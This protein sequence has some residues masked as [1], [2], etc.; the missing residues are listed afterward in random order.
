MPK[1]RRVK[2]AGKSSIRK[3]RSTIFYFPVD[4]EL[5]QVCKQTFLAILGFPPKSNKTIQHVLRKYKEYL[6][7]LSG[8]VDKRR[9]A[10]RE[11]AKIYS[12]ARRMLFRQHIMTSEPSMTHYRRE[13]CLNMKYISRKITT[14]FLEKD[15]KEKITE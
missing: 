7:E 12:E 9:M 10:A 5:K 15:F 13:Y 14:T 3:N 2:I 1:Q 4:S 8:M 6:L 11:N